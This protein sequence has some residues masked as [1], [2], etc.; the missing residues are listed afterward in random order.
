[1]ENKTFLQ[2]CELVSS[3][4]KGLEVNEVLNSIGSNVFF[5]FGNIEEESALPNGKKYTRKEWGI[6]ISL[7]SWRITKDGAYLVGSGDDRNDIDLHIHKLI[8]KRFQSL[9]FLSS[10]LDAEFNFDEGYQLTAFFDW[11]GEDQWTIFLPK[12]YQIEAIGI[13]CSTIEEI[14][15]IR[16]LSKNFP[17]KK[18]YIEIDFPYP[19]ANVTEISYNIHDQPIVHFGDDYSVHFKSCTWRFEKDTDYIIGY[20]DQG[21]IDFKNELSNLIGKKLLQVDVANEMMDGRFQ[22]E[23]GYVLKTFTCCFATNQ[24]KICSKTDL[25]FEAK[26]CLVESESL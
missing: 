3:H 13:D 14:K 21:E 9:Q 26:I 2:A 12:R 16:D 19:S 1:M 4:L 11:A 15:K 25:I 20:R 10:F 6:W 7:P 22:F 24:W 8:G 18:N 5:Y 17:I 23:D